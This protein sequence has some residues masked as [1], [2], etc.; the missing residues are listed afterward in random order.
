[1]KLTIVIVNWNVKE[2]LINCL[3]SIEENR[4]CTFFEVVV[5]DNASS[6]G[7]IEAVKSRFPDVTIITNEQNRGFAV[8]SNQGIE[9]SQGEYILFL[10]PDTIIH[11]GSL[12]SLI[13]FLDNNPRVGVCG[14]K[15]LNGEGTI[16]R[17]VR[18]FPSF[19]G[20]LYRHTA[21]RFLGIFKDEYKKWV[22][23]DFKHNRQMDVDQ[24]MGSALM[25]R[26]SVIDNV[27]DMDE[28]FFMYYEEVD[29]CY[30]IKQ[31]G[32][33]VVFMP[34]AVITHLGGR[35]TGQ[36]P[37]RKRIMAMASLLKFFR[38]HRGKFVTGVFNCVFKPAII[39]RDV[40]NVAAGA[41][42]YIF[43]GIVLSKKG[44]EKSVEKVKKSTI[45]LA[46]YSWLL[47]KM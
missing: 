12:D 31:A 45:L 14:P 35:S 36:I 30:R 16:Q 40:M 42:T 20:V 9:V 7:S 39:V 44:R 18:R 23:K 24:V 19:R 8:A 43:A 41:V 32:W 26:R 29:L 34:E 38:K 22:M 27:G 10:N 25:V 33:R 21:F 4:P 6:D 13:S 47:F 2:D 1:M 11:P 28:K 37:V 46:K 3:R 17:S 5:V 15:L